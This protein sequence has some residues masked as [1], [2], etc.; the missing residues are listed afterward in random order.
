M[1]VMYNDFLILTNCTGRKRA[2]GQ[3]ITLSPT[4]LRGP[5]LSIAESWRR[6]TTLAPRTRT[7]EQTYVGRSFAEARKIS[8]HLGAQLFILSAGLGIVAA[9]ELV[10]HYDLTV[11]NGSNSVR[12]LLSNLGLETSDWWAALLTAF[13]KERS[14]R[15]LVETHPNS[16]VLVALPS[17]YLEMVAADLEEL[18][19]LELKRVRIFSS[20]KG[21]TVVSNRVRSVVLP[22]DDRLEGSEFPGTRNDFAQRALRH[23]TETLG[24]QRLSLLGAESAVLTALAVMNSRQIPIRARKTDAEI[25]KLLTS[26]WGKFDGS[27]TRLLRYLRDDELVACEQSR[28]RNL[29]LAVGQQLANGK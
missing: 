17:S 22:Y 21:R 20:A 18:S 28:F 29:W 25:M 23:F 26:K 13:G 27:S 15:S 8:A 4:S 1:S 6:A 2:G 19:D 5:L 9:N 3:A 7:A 11:V 10:P 16:L 14:L 24:A 12:P